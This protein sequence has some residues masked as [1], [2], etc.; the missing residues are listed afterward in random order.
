LTS[1]VVLPNSPLWDQD[2]PPAA[3]RAPLGTEVTQPPIRARHCARPGGRARSGRP[4]GRLHHASVTTS[5]SEIHGVILNM[6]A[7]PWSV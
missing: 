4:D 2:A 6:P 5:A 1:F 7:G 3:V